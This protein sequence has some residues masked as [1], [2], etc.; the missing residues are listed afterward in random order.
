MRLSLGTKFRRIAALTGLVLVGG[1]VSPPSPAET[2]H[3]A[4]VK[5]NSPVV[6]LWSVRWTETDQGLILSGHVFRHYPEADEDTT[7]SHLAVALL[8]AQGRRL[9]E[10]HADYEPRRIP[11]RPRERGYST[12]SVLVDTLPPGIDRVEI[13]AYEDAPR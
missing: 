6:T 4:L 7:R 10:L 1:C 5:I 13:R 3:P 12:F 2:A 9:R 11:H 8:D